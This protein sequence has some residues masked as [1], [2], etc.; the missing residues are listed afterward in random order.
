MKAQTNGGGVM[1]DSP[2][3]HRFIILSIP[4]SQHV[5]LCFTKSSNQTQ[6]FHKWSP[7]LQFIGVS[8]SDVAIISMQ[9]TKIFVNQRVLNLPLSDQNTDTVQMEDTTFLDLAYTSA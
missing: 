9:S 2:T 6:N 8:R 5:M 1:T 7:P 3:R 4:Q